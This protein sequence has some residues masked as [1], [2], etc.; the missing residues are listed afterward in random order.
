MGIWTVVDM[1]TWRGN[2]MGIGLDPYVEVSFDLAVGR[3]WHND[4]NVPRSI[5]SKNSPPVASYLVPQHAPICSHTNGTS[6]LSFLQVLQ[7]FAVLFT[8]PNYAQAPEHVC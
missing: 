8:C 1:P 5:S 3:Y 7:A 6:L 4:V 2:G